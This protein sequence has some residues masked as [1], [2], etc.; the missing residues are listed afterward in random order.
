VAFPAPWRAK[1]EHV[2]ALAEPCITSGY[3][4]HLRLGDHRHGVKVEAVQ[5]LSVRQS[6]LGEMTL[7]PPSATLGNLV[8]KDGGQEPRRQGRVA[9]GAGGEVCPEELDGRQAQLVEQESDP[10]DIDGLGRL[11]A[12]SPIATLPIRSS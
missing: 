6:S 5:C 3:G 1:Q 7:D 2:C 11:H 9:C 8:F 10:P 12:A 4:H